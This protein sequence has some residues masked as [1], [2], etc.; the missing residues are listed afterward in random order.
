MVVADDVVFEYVLAHSANN[1]AEVVLNDADIV[2]DEVDTVFV[3][4]M[5]ELIVFVID[6]MKMNY[7]EV[8]V[9]FD[10]VD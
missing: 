9:C 2:V 8:E 5:I 4:E 7:D 1:V 3:D 6:V 10:C